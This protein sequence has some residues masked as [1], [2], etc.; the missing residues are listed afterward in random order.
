LAVGDVLTVPNLWRMLREQKHH[1][2]MVINE[3]GS[4]A[5]MVTLEDALEEILGEVY[6]E[7]DQEAEPIV[8]SGRRVSVRGDVLLDLVDDRFGLRLDSDEVD[9]VGGLLWHALGRLP[10][11]GDEIE[12]APGGTVVRVDTMDGRAVG[13]A[14]FELPEASA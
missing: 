5:G 12:V 8:V 9:T 10:E 6:D 13:R 14:S 4:V 3:Y 7:F 1:L 11:V 2:A